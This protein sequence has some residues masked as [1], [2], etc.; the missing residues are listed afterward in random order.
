[1]PTI[2]DRKLFTV[3]VEWEVNPRYQQQF[4]DLICKQIEAHIQNDTGFVSAS[5][6]AS[7]DGQRV[8]NYAQWDSKEDWS[9]SRSSGDD[10]A[11]LAMSK[12]IDRCGAK[13]VKVDTFGVERVVENKHYRFTEGNATRSEVAYPPQNNLRSRGN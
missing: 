13:T 10:E 7:E 6:H 5:F 11:S 8:I 1:M 2:T 9:R 12:A 3:L 4:I